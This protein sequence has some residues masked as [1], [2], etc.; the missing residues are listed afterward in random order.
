MRFCFGAAL[1]LAGCFAPEL[2]DGQ[3]VCGAGG[4]CPPGYGC[5]A[6]RRCW[7]PPADGGASDAAR[8]QARDAASDLGADLGGGGGG[9]HGGHGGG[10]D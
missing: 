5:G 9:G 3:V 6:D 8:P 4:E 1:L 7:R 10:D 2:G